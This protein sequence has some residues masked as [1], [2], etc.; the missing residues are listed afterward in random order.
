MAIPVLTGPVML[1]QLSANASAQLVNTGTSLFAFFRY[2][3]EDL[4]N[5]PIALATGLMATSVTPIG[6]KLVEQIIYF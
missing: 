2:N 3:S 1:S 6:V 5:V 4:V